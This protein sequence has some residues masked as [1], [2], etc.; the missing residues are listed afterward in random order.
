MAW[1]CGVPMSKR[2]AHCGTLT[3][4][5]KVSKDPESPS[6]ED[7]KAGLPHLHTSLGKKSAN[8]YTCL[9]KRRCR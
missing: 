9:E 7:Q 1:I 8:G 3:L 2:A 6:S 4:K 5:K